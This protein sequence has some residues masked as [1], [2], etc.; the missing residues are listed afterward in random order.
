MYGGP[1][2]VLVAFIETFANCVYLKKHGI[3]TGRWIVLFN[4]SLASLITTF[5]YAVV[6][7]TGHWNLSAAVVSDTRSLFTALGII[8]LSQFFASS[9]FAAVYQN[10]SSNQGIWDTWKKQCLSSSLAS[11]TGAALAALIYKL[12]NYGD[13]VIAAL[14]SLIVWR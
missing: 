11:F 14:M 7:V 13:P 4:S 10:I 5:T 3:M 9:I 6:S 8:S 1:A 12:I 2:A